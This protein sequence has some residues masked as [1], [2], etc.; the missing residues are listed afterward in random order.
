MSGRHVGTAMV[1]SH[2][3]QEAMSVSRV[4]VLFV[5][6]AVAVGL[7]L[8]LLVG[9]LIRPEDGKQPTG[10]PA[11]QSRVWPVPVGTLTR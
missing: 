5:L 6:V 8:M 9:L 4:K 1:E 2:R 11:P 3:Y 10:E 7:L